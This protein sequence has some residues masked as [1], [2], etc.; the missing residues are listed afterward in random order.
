MNQRNP[1]NGRSVSGKLYNLPMRFHG[2]I[3]KEITTPNPINR[4]QMFKVLTGISWCACFFYLNVVAT[5]DIEK[6]LSLIGFAITTYVIIKDKFEAR[7]HKKRMR[8][9]EY[10][11]RKKRLEQINRDGWDI[12]DHLGA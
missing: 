6:V 9:L 5:V 10:E 4:T 2:D 8:E 12:E 7:K 1:A 11:E 3:S